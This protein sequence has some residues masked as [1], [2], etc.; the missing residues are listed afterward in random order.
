MII[1]IRILVAL[2]LVR[3]LIPRIYRIKIIKIG[4]HRLEGIGIVVITLKYPIIS[5]RF[6]GLPLYFLR[7]EPALPCQ[8]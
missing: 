7:T 5:S 3:I 1:F 6:K 8:L 2:F 4:L